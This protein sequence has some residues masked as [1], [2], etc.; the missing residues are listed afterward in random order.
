MSPMLLLPLTVE[1]F[2]FQKVV[3][4]VKVGDAKKLKEKNLISGS[5]L[6]YGEID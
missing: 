5:C 4:V 3:I 2:F 1:S 6:R